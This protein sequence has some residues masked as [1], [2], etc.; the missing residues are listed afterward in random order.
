MMDT[1]LPA[2]AQDYPLLNVFWTML[3]FSLWVLWLFLVFRVAIDIFRSRDLSGW[4][5]AGWLLF[6]IVLPFLGVLTYL[7][8][9]GDKMYGREARDV[10]S[11]IDLV[12]DA[13][14]QAAGRHAGAANGKADELT[15]LAALH[16]K[17]VLTDAEFATQKATVLSG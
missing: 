16:D 13:P 14:P 3:W 1:A 6:V 7:I 15:K 4:G 10:Q 11:S 5:R 12:S 17:G 2:A 8:V 9:R